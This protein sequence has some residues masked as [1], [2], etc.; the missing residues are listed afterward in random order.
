MAII[1]ID[2]G[3]TNSLASVWKDG[4]AELIP[5]RLGSFLTPSVVAEEN[6][7]IWV[8]AVAKEKRILKPEQSAAS[9]KRFMGTMYKS[10]LGERWYSSQELSA[11]VLRQLK[12]DAE[13]YLGE[14]VE[15]AVISV[16]AYF[17]DEQRFATKQA[18]VLAGLKVERLINE[19]SAAALSCRNPENEEDESFLVIDFGGGTLDVS[20]VECFEQVIEIL[21]VSGD[22]K[23]GGNDFDKRIAEYFC[24]EHG[25]EYDHLCQQHRLELLK[26]AEWCKRQ[27]TEKNAGMMEWDSPDGKKGL[28]LTSEDLIRISAP[29]LKRMEEVV[30]K[31]LRDAS[32]DVGEIDKVVL[33]GG[34]CRMPVIRQYIHHFMGVEPVLA[35]NPDEIVAIGAGTYAGIKERKEEIRDIVLTDICPFTLGVG[36]WDESS[37]E[38]MLSPVIERNCVLP[39]SREEIFEPSTQTQTKVEIKIYQGESMYCKKNLFLGKVDLE[40]PPGDIRNRLVNVRFTYDINGILE[41]E[42]VNRAGTKAREVIVN[43]GIRMS[44]EEL[45]QK[46]AQIKELKY[47]SREEEKNEFLFARAERLYQES[48]GEERELV[49]RNRHWLDSVIKG[50]NPAAIHAAQKQV[51]QVFDYLEEK[52]GLGELR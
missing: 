20:V 47:V 32:M 3:T 25:L 21:A 11:M 27:L 52:L 24:R 37:R 35:G 9:F 39:F 8:G 36:V 34:T 49:M 14:Q 38:L 1:G 5:N 28:I 18:G 26:S 13:E 10:S 30:W 4:H 44:E 15:E 41:V 40:I 16:P 17:N 51:G 48:L 23:L 42:A 50:K 7:E 29:V 31:A 33:V 2:L 19:P 6:G 46:I 22:N 12:A 45:N 43:S